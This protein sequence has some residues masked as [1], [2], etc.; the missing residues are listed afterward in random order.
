MKIIV[1]FGIKLFII[2]RIVTVGGNRPHLLDYEKHFESWLKVSSI[3]TN[4]L[5]ITPWKFITTDKAYHSEPFLMKWKA[6]VWNDREIR[7]RFEYCMEKL[8]TKSWFLKQTWKFSEDSLPSLKKIPSLVIFF[9]HFFSFRGFYN[10][11][12]RF[13]S[14]TEMN[15]D[16]KISWDKFLK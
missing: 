4:L 10:S 13:Y 5:N 11:F 8:S 15:Y 16:S 2:S 14:D 9:K 1:I 6:Q 12:I 7:N 3:I